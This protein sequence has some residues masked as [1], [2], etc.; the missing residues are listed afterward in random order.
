MKEKILQNCQR[1]G[2][3]QLLQFVANGTVTLEELNDAGLQPEKAKYIQDNLAA[4]E[5]ALYQKAVELNSI[6]ACDEYLKTYPFG[7]PC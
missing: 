2:A 5:N 4:L 6:K 1:V 7:L 3:Q